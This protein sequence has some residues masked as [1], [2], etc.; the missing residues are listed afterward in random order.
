MSTLR[1]KKNLLIF[2]LDPNITSF[3]YNTIHDVID[4]EV[5]IFALSSGE[6]P[7]TTVNPDLIMLSNEAVRQE[8]VSLFPRTEILVPKRIITCFNLEKLLRL[9]K[10]HKVLL[11]NHPRAATEDTIESLINFGIDHL[12]YVPYWIGKEMDID[13]IDT[14]VS[15]G[16]THLVPKGIE[17]VID[18]GPR[19]IS[20]HSFLQL[21]ILLNLDLKYLEIFV[22]SYHN[23]LI[24]SSRK[25]TSALDRSET[26]RKHMEI[27]FDEF[28]DGLVS[29]N[30]DER[31]D[32]VNTSVINL[33]NIDRENLINRRIGELVGSFEKLAD[34]VV[35]S[36]P[37]SRSAGIYSHNK[38]KI[39]IN[40]IPVVGSKIKSQI[41]TFRE[42]ERIQEIE[43]N[44]RM[45][46]QEKGYV[47][48]Y[49][50]TD[51]WSKS[52]LFLAKLDKARNF[53]KTEMN[54]LITGESGTGKELFAHVIHKN[55]PR[56]NGPFVAVNFAGLPESLIESEL[57]GYE[58]GAFTGAKR[59]GK[60]GLFEQAHG[61]TIFLDEI[62]DAP[63]NVQSRLL[64]VLQEKEVMRVGGSKIVPVNVRVIAATN[65]D[66]NA[67]IARHEFRED[68]YYRINTLPIEIPPLMD[69]KDDLIY[70]INKYMKTKYKIEK[71]MSRQVIDC[72][73]AYDW[74]GNIR[75]LINATEYICFTSE[76]KTCVELNH[77]P[78][79]IRALSANS[80]EERST[81]VVGAFEGIIGDL[82]ADCSTQGMIYRLLTILIQRKNLVT[83]RNSLLKE[84][85]KHGHLLTEG[86]MK[87]LLKRLELAQFVTV[88]KTKQGTVITREGEKFLSDRQSARV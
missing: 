7:K 82:A 16:M 52:E 21:L 63:L 28:D 87:R 27:I 77:L 23:L 48:K 3:L 6:T 73:Q 45:M 72:I 36:N 83:G 10:N 69:R 4:Q 86:N 71:Q 31:I 74:P 8:A 5:N 32:R 44:V 76:G 35:D 17:N 62:G 84:M 70:I 85:V 61:G 33:L 15:P 37:G 2:S 88:G 49:D 24:E 41:Y 46:L 65:K 59:G 68:L 53:A 26:L 64:R 81:H 1:P 58:D 19:T 54:I 55:S 43:E 47:T 39:L 29:V 79:R 9:P 75:E 78:D 38:R 66:L 11:V 13:G 80:P 42:I 67:A 40:S 20:T 12:D 22:N 18:I 57:F 51:I 50:C 14:A 60:R 30:E 56:N 25:L 34:L